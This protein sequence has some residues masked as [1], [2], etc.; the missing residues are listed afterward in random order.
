[1][2]KSIQGIMTNYVLGNLKVSAEKLFRPPDKGGLGLINVQSF[3][4]GLQ[5]V[6]VKRAFVSS[7]DN[8]RIAMRNCSYGNPYVMCKKVLTGT[9]CPL[10]TDIASS[11]ETFVRAFYH[12]NNNI[13]DSYLLYNERLKRSVNS[14]QLID[15][16]FFAGNRPLLNMEKLAFL[17]ISDIVIGRNLKGL[18]ELDDDL[19]LHFNLATY[20]RLGE[21]ITL[22]FNRHPVPALEPVLQKSQSVARFLQKNGGEAKRIRQVIDEYSQKR[23][24]LENFTTF[25]TYCRLTGADAN[26]FLHSSKVFGF[27]AQNFLNNKIRDFIFRY[28]NNQLPLNT[29]LSHYVENNSR[30]CQLCISSGVNPLTDETFIHLFLDCPVSS[31]IQDWFVRRYFVNLPWDN[32]QKRRFLFF[33]YFPGSDNFN[34]FA[35]FVA[36]T[37]QYIIWDM[38][39]QKRVLEPLT[40]DEDFRFY[41]NHSVR[42]SG[43]LRAEMGKIGDFFRP[44]P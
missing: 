32:D 26:N 22:F 9:V 4:S 44:V 33:G 21:A 14:V 5:A 8:W 7:R 11:Y 37:I 31:R 20:M 41:T 17:K 27:W 35:F 24:C 6:W 18:D 15:E 12:R 43:F 30:H 25:K 23:T 38:K 10:L 2:L 3:I 34:Y 16:A 36:M 39:I 19:G 40:L 29:R 28:V 42:R 1:M 13:M